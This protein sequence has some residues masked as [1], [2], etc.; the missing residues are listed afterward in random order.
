M[1]LLRHRNR[2]EQHAR[3]LV[4]F[5]PLKPEADGTPSRQPGSLSSE[6]HDS[7]YV[8]L[9][10]KIV[11]KE[12]LVEIINTYQLVSV[13][14]KTKW[15]E[16]CQDFE[17]IHNFHIKI[18]YKL[19]TE[20]E[21]YGFAPVWWHQLLEDTPF[22]EWLEFDPLVRESRGRLIAEKQTDYSSE[23]LNILNKHSIRYSKEESYFRVWGYI[24][25][26]ANPEIV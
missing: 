9:N 23:I 7:I 10:K 17:A 25:G 6:G 13:M 20:D 21:I 15:R 4:Y 19:I 8:Q 3:I 11:M 16:L 5:R 18:R 22:I 12:R 26:D 2:W 14:N 1:R 24:R